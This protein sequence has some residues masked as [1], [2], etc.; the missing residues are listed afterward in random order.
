MKRTVNARTLTL[1][2]VLSALSA[3]LMAV[4]FPLPFAPTFLKFDI[5]EFPGLFAGF[6]LGP[7]AGAVVIVLKNLL[8]LFLQGSETMYVGELMNVLGSMIFTLP[9]S[10]IYKHRRDIKGARIALIV[11]TIVCSL[12]WIPLNL[13]IGFPMYAAVFGMPL[14]AIVGMGASVNPLI[15][16]LPTLM[17]LGILP[18]NIV[19]LSVTSFVTWWLYKKAGNHLRSLVRLPASGA[20]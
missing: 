20:L 16:N 3:V 1:I 5:A 18:F 15:T 13:Y 12:A 8:K 11:S 2:A 14:E 6:F 10:F 9:A 7:G 17:L 19:K 4:N